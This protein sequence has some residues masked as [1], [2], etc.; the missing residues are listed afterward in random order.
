M[1]GTLIS[2]INGFKKIEDIQVGDVVLSKD[3]TSGK[4]VYKKVTEL[5]YHE[6]DTLFEIRLSNGEIIETTWNHPFYIENRGWTEAKDLKRGDRSVL[7]D[8]SSMEIL[9]VEQE[10]RDELVYNF[11]VDEN[12]TYYVGESG[13]LVHNDAAMYLMFP[14]GGEGFGH[15]A[16]VSVKKMKSKKGYIG[17]TKYREYG[18]Y[19]NYLDL[20]GDGKIDDEEKKH[21]NQAGIVKKYPKGTL[22]LY[23]DEKGGLKE[24]S[25]KEFIS[26]VSRKREKP[27]DNKIV[28]AHE[29]IHIINNSRGENKYNGKKEDPTN[30][31]YYNHIFRDG[32]TEIK[33][34]KKE[35]IY[36]VGE[37]KI[38]ADKY[39]KIPLQHPKDSLIN[40]AKDFLG[41]DYYQE[42]TE[43]MIRKEHNIS[44]KRLTYLKLDKKDEPK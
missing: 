1:A 2:T 14:E 29:L 36:T 41:I 19:G 26:D 39:G 11:E 8:G 31:V 37:V 3:E 44:D 34:V 27:I 12:H 13:V 28:I 7:A 42:Y 15:S 40:L 18:R 43:N 6:V 22:D 4:I 17:N 21:D 10:Y 9:S 33:S 25:L 16:I 38:Y 32:S 35:E 23:Y 5:F 20:N 24:E 30:Y